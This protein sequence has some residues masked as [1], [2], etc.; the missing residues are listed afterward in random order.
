M[1]VSPVPEQYRT[2]TPHLTVSDAAAA[3][4][5]YEEAFGA[6]EIA[7]M[8]GPDDKVM[9]AEI[10][11]GDSVV[12]LNDEFPDFGG[13]G[14][15]A[16]GGTPVAIHL[17]VE[18]CDAMM[19]QALDAGATETMAMQDV[20]WG[21]RFGGVEDPFGHKWNIASRKQNLTLEQIQEGAK[22]AFGG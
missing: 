3:I 16:L 4:E 17:Y 8:G 7:R 13:H 10:R 11:I 1:T 19:K 9:H 14:P 21:D 2:V 5:F 15:K 22:A 18:D 6:E 20:F 12:M